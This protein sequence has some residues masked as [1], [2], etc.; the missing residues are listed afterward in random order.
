MSKAAYGGARHLSIVWAVTLAILTLMEWRQL[1]HDPL[2]REILSPFI[3]R[4]VTVFVGNAEA[5]PE[6]TA[7]E[8]ARR[9]AEPGPTRYEVEFHFNG[10]LFLV[11]FFGPVLAF[12]GIAQLLGKLRGNRS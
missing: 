7:G 9:R 6:Q 11:C 8:T 10:P 1:D 5:A 3:E 12:H 2:N 4:E